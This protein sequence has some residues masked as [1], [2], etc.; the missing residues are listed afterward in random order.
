LQLCFNSPMLR[1]LWVLLTLLLSSCFWSGCSCCCWALAVLLLLLLLLLL[2]LRGLA[3]APLT[4]PE[5]DV[6]MLR[7][8]DLHA[9]GCEAP[10]APAAAPPAAS[11]TVAG[12]PASDTCIK[13]LLLRRLLRRLNV[14]KTKLSATSLQLL[15]LLLRP[16]PALPLAAG[17]SCFAVE[18][19]SPSAVDSKSP[20]L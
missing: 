19:C 1:E 9:P 11:R 8:D 6:T 17:A 5:M 4:A 13:L 12:L 10:R 7:N 3:P 15:L 18:S 14:E 20:R 2:M 16:P